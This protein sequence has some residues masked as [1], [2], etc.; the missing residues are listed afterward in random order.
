MDIRVTLTRVSNEPDPEGF[1]EF[2]REWLEEEYPDCPLRVT[3]DFGDTFSVTV[4]GLEN[5]EDAWRVGVFYAQ[6]FGEYRS[7]RR[8]A[9]PPSPL[10]L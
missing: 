7:K 6:A 2:L 1:A 4:N 8:G 3:I 10:F 5:S 9:Q